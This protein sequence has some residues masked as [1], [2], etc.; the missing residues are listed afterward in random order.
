[1][2][3]DLFNW[4]NRTPE[5]EALQRRL[6]ELALYEQAVN[7]R[8]SQTGGVGGGSNL[9]QRRT[10]N[11]ETALFLVREKNKTTYTYYVADFQRGTLSGP[12]DTGISYADYYVDYSYGL[13]DKGYFFLFRLDSDNNDYRM[14][15]LDRVG[16][17]LSLV[18]GYTSDLSINY[19]EG[20]WLVANDYDARHLWYFDGE[21]FTQNLTYLQGTDGFN[22]GSEFDGA[23]PE[24]FMLRSEDNTG[25]QT[26][27]LVGNS[28]I[29]TLFSEG[30]GEYRRFLYNRSN[31]AVIEEFDLNDGVYSKL[32]FISVTT[33]TTLAVLNVLA[34]E[35]TTR[36]NWN[37]G[38]GNYLWIFSN[39]TQWFIVNYRASSSTIETRT[40]SSTDY[41]NYEFKSDSFSPNSYNDYPIH[42]TFVLNFYEPTGNFENN[43][44]EVSAAK[45]IYSVAGSSLKEYDYKTPGVGVALIDLNHQVNKNVIA[46]FTA[47]SEYS[48]IALTAGV[49]YVH[50]LGIGVSEYDG[51]SRFRTSEKIAFYFNL[52]TG[53]SVFFVLNSTGSSYTDTVLLGEEITTRAVAWDTVLLQA[54]SNKQWRLN[55]ATNSLVE[56][57]SFSQRWT[58]EP[59]TNPQL[60]EDDRIV[61]LQPGRVAYTHTQMTDPP[62]NNNDEAQLGD[63]AMDGAIVAGTPADFGAGSSYFTNLY[64][65]AFVLCAKNINI[66]S[67]SID[68][69]IGA[70]GGGNVAT[71]IFSTVVGGQRYTAYMKQVFDSN[72]PSIVHIIIVNGDGAGISQVVD[73][74]TEDDLHVISGIPQSVNQLH[75]L[76]LSEADSNLIGTGDIEQIIDEYLNIVHNK[77]ISTILSDLNLNYEDVT[78][79]VATPFLFNDVFDDDDDEGPGSIDDGGED[80]Y[81]GA[82]I[83][84]TNRSI[85][86]MRIITSTAAT[87]SI[88]VGIPSNIGV[89]E[90]GKEMIGIVYSD[91]RNSGKIS[92]NIYDTS[93]VLK[94]YIKT[95]HF[96]YYDF[97]IVGTRATMTAMDKV[98]DGINFYWNT[99]LYSIS[100]TS[101]KS[102]SYQS[103]DSDGFRERAMN[104]TR[105]YD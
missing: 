25:K 99:T 76:L 82:N 2:S 65:G 43:L 1:M 90:N 12:I 14:L 85:T 73:P 101:H 75:Y 70:D 67:F 6:E 27:A 32:R 72:D 36:Q 42:N 8:T 49:T 77:N 80:M 33:G 74:T 86:Q 68:G 39:A 10:Q 40:I 94:Q 21:K 31:A 59:Y 19:F 5:Q 54:A 71:D 63:F 38:D 60:R 41:P 26:I 37:Y 84:S 53:D 62:I 55:L 3:N 9:Y 98:F 30:P 100:L 96:E 104:D 51:L 11:P 56:I 47:T 88:L 69:N 13:Q 103:L 20:L 91:P 45:L 16:T 78:S 64:P 44:T 15:F 29:K 35:Y 18:E 105:W 81:D 89:L 46:V 58:P 28:G 48:V 61:Q 83:I 23:T 57:P 93:G 17:R 79:L 50:P 92:V 52:T 34:D 95:P 66:T 4:G 97:D 102:K 22:L 24:G 7:A 87:T